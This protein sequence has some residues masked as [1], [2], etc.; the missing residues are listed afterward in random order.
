MS[1]SMM[2]AQCAA[3]LINL[4]FEPSNILISH[5]IYSLS[6][7]KSSLENNYTN[8]NLLHISIDTCLVKIRQGYLRP[9]SK[10]TYFGNFCYRPKNPRFGAG[11]QNSIT[12]PFGTFQANLPGKRYYS[13]F[14]FGLSS[15]K[16]VQK[17]LILL[18][19]E[20]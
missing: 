15:P 19:C 16:L 17:S 13:D 5:I 2:P 20:T 10:Y 1:N 4:S 12:C 6:S 3:M 11:V 7:A 9:M 8:A 18:Y 14:F